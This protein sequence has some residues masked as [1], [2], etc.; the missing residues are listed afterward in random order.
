VNAMTVGA[1]PIE[2]LLIEDSIDEA[3]LTMDTLREGRVSNRVHWV[4]D[5]E[6]GLAFLAREGRHAAAPRPDLILLDLNMPRMGG[7]EVLAIIKDHPHWRRIPVVVMTQSAKDE[8]IL[9][10]YDRHANCYVTKPLDLAKFMEA[11]RSIEDF[12]L[13]IVRLPAA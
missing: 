5:G 12:W 2:I 8:D 13:S 3:Q 11:V 7:Q 1:R 4:E 6:E 9:A 10:A